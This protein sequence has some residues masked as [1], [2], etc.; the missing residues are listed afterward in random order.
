MS[1]R[2][3]ALVTGGARR[4][5]AAIVR[6]L[7]KDGFAVVIHCNQSITDGEALAAEIIQSG[8]RAAVVTAD[9][10]LPDPV[11]GLMAKAAMP[12]GPP[13][14]LVNNAS[15]FL[16]DRLETIDV[17]Q[18]NRQLSVNIRA[19]SVL[20]KDF[21]ALLPVNETGAIV[22]IIDQR[23]MKLTP[24][25]YSYTLSK[26]ALHAATRTAA[27]ALAPR[28]RV[29]GVGPGPTLGN[30]HDGDKGVAHEAANV[31]LQRQ[32]SPEEIAAAVIYLVGAR[33]V[34]GQMIAVDGGQHIAWQTPDIV[35]Q[36]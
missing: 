30:I 3:V 9:L 13:T 24:E 27:Q 1:E 11:A 16:D 6:A 34:T 17:L 25:F 20:M 8:G 18:W 19:P 31:P 28:I 2:K 14:V 21:A 23:V 32:V 15:L 26:V 12:F 10:A 35:T 36:P 5:G 29:N 4:I 22:N 33:S 7:A